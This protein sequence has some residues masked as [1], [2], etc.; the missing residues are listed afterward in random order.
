MKKTIE[1]IRVKLESASYKKEEHVRIG[2]VARIC[3]VLGWDIWDPQEFYTEFP[4]KMRNKEGSVDV[5]LFHSNLKDK[6]PD[7]FFELKAVGKL[8]GN[9]ESSEEQLQ[10]YNFYNTASITVLT[11]GKIWRFYLSSATGTFRQKLFC[12]LNLL[13]DDYERINKIFHDILCKDYFARGAVNCAEKMLSD[14]KLSS[15]IERAKKEANLKSDDYPELTKYELVQLI[16]KERGHE[17]GIDEIIRLWNFKSDIKNEEEAEITIT[18]MK[19][20]DKTPVTINSSSEWLI[21]PIDDDYSY[22]K[23]RRIYVIDQWYPVKNWRHA[24][25]VVYDRFLPELLKASLPKTMAITRNSKDF[26]EPL[27]FDGGYYAEA[28]LST[29]TIISH[30]RRALQVVG[31]D[32]DSVVQIEASVNRSHKRR[33]F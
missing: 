30:I 22:R 33:S 21:G 10:E 5:A 25:K 3:Q 16:L 8:K 1:D 7:V 29:N 9:I 28:S 2:I 14:L 4:I 31:Y 15:E 23:V 13:E 6:A 20:P 32:A 11:D 18:P 17:F 27:K 12:S 24:K 26:R 19:L